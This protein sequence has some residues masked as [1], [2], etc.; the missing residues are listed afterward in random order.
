[1]RD[2]WSALQPWSLGIGDYVNNMVEVEE[3]RIRASYGA[4]KY[5]RLARIKR[6]YDPDDVF[7]CN[8]NIPPV[9][10]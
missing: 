8:V 9:M 6:R 4:E 1:M 10:E 7:R 2:V 5:D 3:D